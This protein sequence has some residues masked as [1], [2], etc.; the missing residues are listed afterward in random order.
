MSAR[1][2]EEP[3]RVPVN[4]QTWSHLTFL[5]FRYD[6]GT[7]QR[8]VPAPLRVQE[9]DGG[10]WVGL[11]PFTMSDVRAPGL[12]APPGWDAFAELNVRTYV[13]APDG[14]DGLWFLRLF[15]P[16]T[17]FALALRSIGLPYRRAPG[18]VEP[19][20]D[21]WRYAFGPP[22]GAGPR[23]GAG[24]TAQ[25][26]VGPPLRSRDRTPEIDSLTGRWSAF[27]RRAG[28]LWRTPVRH[29]AWPL[30]HASVTGEPTAPLRWA[31]LPPPQEPP[32]VHASPGVRTT[33]GPPRPAVLRPRRRPAGARPTRPGR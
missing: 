9:W 19:D 12:P 13:R 29:E 3:V 17:S 32:M 18:R 15:V 22:R 30:H 16:R 26:R 6:T 33:V 2:P 24:F 27:H 28:V 11:T 5:H 14:R 7:V 25:T 8:L 4:L 20:G 10:T 23:A 21:R 31:G 1:E